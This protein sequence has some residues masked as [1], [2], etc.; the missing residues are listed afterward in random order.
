MRSMAERRA[1]NDTVAPDLIGLDVDSA[2]SVCSEAHLI[3]VG[4][5]SDG[6]LGSQTWPGLWIVTDQ[7]PDL[8]VTVA[9]GDAV[10]IE[11]RKQ[12]GG[13]AGD[14]EPRNPIPSANPISA[15]RERHEDR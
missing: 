5:N 14:R 10:V 12:G 7:R 8:G 13:E 4:S 6:I 11:F 15:S 2:R 3:A 9:R 1:D